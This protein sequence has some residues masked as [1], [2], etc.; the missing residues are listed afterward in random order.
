[1]SVPRRP[2]VVLLMLASACAAPATQRGETIVFASGADLQSINPLLTTHPLARQIQRYALLTTLVQYDSALR[3]TPYLARRWEWSDDSLLLTWHLATAVRWHD[4]APTTATDVAWTLNAA[5]DPATGYPRLSD[6]ASVAAVVA[7]DDSTVRVSFRQAPHRI[8]DV[9]TD[10]AVLPAHLLAQVP[11]AGLRLAAWNQSPVGNGPFR[12]VSHT[13]N[14]RWVFAANPAFPAMLGGAPRIN[15][16]VIAVVDEPTTKLAALTVGELDF[17]GIQPAH[18]EFVR[19]DPGLAVVTYP[20]LLT[21]AVVFNT[22]RPPLDDVRVRRAISLAID[23]TAIVNGYLFGFGAAI[24][25]PIPDSSGA[26]PPVPDTASARRLLG[27]RSIHLELLTVGSGEA[28]LEQMLQSQLAAIGVQVTIRQLEL[29]SFLDRVQGRAHEFDA[30]VLGIP[31]DL[32]LGQLAPLLNTAGV[33]HADDQGAMLRTIADS[34]PA[35]FLYQAGGVQGMNRR[36]HG[37]R[38][39][40][41]GELASLRDWYVDR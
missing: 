11:H 39:D 2:F 19:R 37:V 12:F 23:R 14:R 17:A 29:T 30:A 34:M 9:F 16:L 20:L 4:G 32:G 26:R 13:P 38:M 18:A 22:R 25:G 31:G 10:L 35:A 21:Y 27:G 1:L 41:R 6:L 40:V 8:P 7:T 3:I 33:P 28:A 5:R 24:T 36:V 15:R